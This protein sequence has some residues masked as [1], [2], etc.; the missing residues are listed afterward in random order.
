[1]QFAGLLQPKDEIEGIEMESKYA[2][3]EKVY[4]Y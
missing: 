1:M 2:N 3:W 4:C